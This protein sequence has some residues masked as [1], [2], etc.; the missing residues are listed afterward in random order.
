MISH[1]K[2]YKEIYIILGVILFFAFIVFV[3]N[4]LR[5]DYFIAQGD[6]YQGIFLDKNLSSYLFTWFKL[7]GQGQFNPLVTTFPYYL[8]QFF[9]EKIGFGYGIIA[10]ILMFAFMALSFLSFYFSIKIFRKYFDLAKNF[11]AEIFASVFY[12]LNVFTFQILTYS[13]GYLHHFYIYIFV[14]IL[15]IVPLKIFLQPKL[16]NYFYFALLF[17]V[18]LPAFNNVAF[19]FI[20]IFFQVILYSLLLLFSLEIKIKDVIL[21]ISLE[22][23]IGLVVI[24]PFLSSEIQFVDK[25]QSTQSFGGDALNYVRATSNS[26]LNIFSSQIQ[27]YH[28]PVVNLFD[29]IVFKEYLPMLF[30]LP[31]LLIVIPLLQLKKNINREHKKAIIVFFI[32]FLSTVILSARI[33]YP[34]E[35]ITSFFFKIPGS[36]LFRSPDKIFIYLQF[37]LT[38]LVFLSLRLINKRI[39]KIFVFFLFLVSSY[40]FYGGGITKYLTQGYENNLITQKADGYKVLVKIPDEYLKLPSVID[41]DKKNQSIISLPYS[42]VNSLNWSN[43]PKWNFVGHDVLFLL[44]NKPYISANMYDHPTK[45][46]TLSFRNFEQ[47]NAEPEKLLEIIKS[48]GGQYVIYHKDIEPSWLENSIH[49][50]NSLDSLA[51]QGLISQIEDNSY[52]T[53]YKLP[54]NE[55]QPLIELQGGSLTFEKINPVKYRLLLHVTNDSKLVFLQSFNSQWKLF[56]QKTPATSWCKGKFLY[57]SHNALECDDANTFFNFSDLG[58]LLGS[59]FDKEH[60][61]EGTYANA[62]NLSKNEILRTFSDGQKKVNSDGSVDIE[63][64]LYFV[65]QTYFYYGIVIIILVLSGCFLKWLS[66]FR[67]NISF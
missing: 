58:M 42:V 40:M 11:W 22:L 66:I 27:K 39:L 29:G 24:L 7:A 32:I 16:I 61:M 54:N 41:S 15:M 60:S 56:A 12:A 49:T 38:I 5:S 63:L 9:L 18:A 45:E 35:T 62:W 52:F 67:K 26:L 34:F 2:K 13:Y 30:F 8:S 4:R 21:V 53:L 36:L 46:T 50:K 3:C 37:F 57:Q 48:F 10:N 28:F 31:Y 64:I 19:L 59:K 6:F 33:A 14:P 25:L 17:I 47:A 51:Q 1:I 23:L 65:P 43:Y 55:L 44:F 20:L